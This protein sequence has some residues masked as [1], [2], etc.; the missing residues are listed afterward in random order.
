M[1]LSKGTPFFS[2]TIS[3]SYSSGCLIMVLGFIVLL[4]I[5]IISFIIP[6]RVGPWWLWSFWLVGLTALWFYLDSKGKGTLEL[7]KG[8]NGQLKVYVKSRE[9]EETVL[10]RPSDISFWFYY[11]YHEGQISLVN[12]YCVITGL[13]GNKISFHQTNGGKSIPP[14]DWLHLEKPISEKGFYYI[15]GKIVDFVNAIRNFKG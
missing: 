13:D 3:K 4:T 9:K 2:T 12:Y 15:N 10:F 11:G 6:E 5:L 8:V 14:A 1:D 7:C